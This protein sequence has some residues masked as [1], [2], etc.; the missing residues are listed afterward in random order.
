MSRAKQWLACEARGIWCERVLRLDPEE[1][2]REIRQSL[3]DLLDICDQGDDNE[4]RIGAAIDA[5]DRKE[6]PRN[7][8]H[9]RL[10]AADTDKLRYHIKSYIAECPIACDLIQRL[11]VLHGQEAPSTR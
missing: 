6:R 11:L 5:F 9:F 3:I 10:S 8:Q 2:A 4:S 7:P 1:R